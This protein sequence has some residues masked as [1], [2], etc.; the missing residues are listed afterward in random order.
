MF[1]LEKPTEEEKGIEIAKKF[2]DEQLFQ[3]SV[4]IP[5]YAD[6]VNYLACGIMPPEFSYQQKRKLRTD[7]RFYI[8]DEP[9]LF[10]RGANLIIKICV[11]EIEKGKILDKCHASHHMEDTLYEIKQPKKFSN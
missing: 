2:H 8:W 1:R 9:L 7:S 11:P 3:L 6:I 10:K 4:Q 5:W